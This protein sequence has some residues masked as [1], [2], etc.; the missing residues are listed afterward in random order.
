MRSG[1]GFLARIL[2]C[3]SLAL[4][5]STA[6]PGQVQ[7]VNMVPTSNSG[8][9]QR[10]S[11]PNIAVDPAN[12][13]SITASVF[14]PDPNG[15]LLGVLYFSIDGG[16]NWNLTPGFA[17]AGAAGGCIAHFCDVSLRYGST[18]GLL[19]LADL[20]I[21]GIGNTNLAVAQITNITATPP[22]YTLL[23]TRTGTAGSY[24]DQPWVEATTVLE[25]AGTGNDHTYVGNNNT[26][27]AT[28]TASVDLSLNPVPPAPSGFSADVIDASATCGQD[29]PSVRTAI[30][31]SGTV[32]IGFY[33]WT[34]SC[35]G[36]PGTAD[37]VVVRDDNW[38][39]GPNAF[40]A[41]HDL[42]NASIGQRV[43]TGIQ[44]PW[45]Q[46]LGTQRV[47]SQ[48]A[49]AVDPNDS[50]TVYIAWGDGGTGATYTLHVRHSTDSGQHWDAADLR[51]INTATNPGL[52]INSHGKVA[53][54]YQQQSGGNWHTIVERTTNAFT[55]HQDL[56]LAN[57][58]DQKGTY[59]GVNPIG[60]YDNVI[61]SSKDFYGIFSGFNTANNAN[62]PNA[63]TYQRQANFSTHQLFADAGHTMPVV[64]SIDP[65]F[66]HITE[67]AAD[68]D[69]YVRDWTNSTAPADHDNGQEPSTNTFFWTSSDVWNRSTNSAGT[70]NANDQ[71]STD[72]MQAGLAASG[73]NF[74]FV[75]VHRNG[76]GSAASV[77][78][79]FLVSPFGTGSAFQDADVAPDPTLNFAAGDQVQVLSSGYHWH[80]DPIAST[81]ACV[82]VQISSANDPFIPPGLAGSVPGWPSGIAIVEDNN[83]AQRNLDVSH[84]LSDMGAIDYALVH[85]AALFSRD[86][87][88]RYQA[89]PERAFKGEIQV[90]GGETKPFRSGDS[91]VLKNMQPG[92][93]RWIALRLTQPGAA[94]PVNFFEMDKGRTVNGF[95]I[96]AE[97]AALS[98]V[99]MENMRE[100][101]HA[102]LRLAY[103]FHLEAG[104]T[105]SGAAAQLL[106]E[107]NIS[108]EQ[109]L[110]FLDQHSKA[111]GTIV[112]ELLKNQKEKDVFDVLRTMAAL[113]QAVQQ[114]NV[115]AA[116]S[117]HSVLLH[118]LDAFTTMLQ[119]ADGD[120]ADMLQMVRWQEALYRSKRLERISCSVQLVK[121]SHEFIRG[122]GKQ[123]SHADSYASLMR[124]LDG[125]FHETSER[126]EKDRE[127]LEKAASE[128]EHNIG[129][130][131]ARLEKAHREF[132]I[133]LASITQ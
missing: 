121:E 127:D 58:P 124:G 61:A 60:D 101:A 17:P 120:P 105:E 123:R 56:T 81:H 129:E 33:R 72:P 26:Q 78:A 112:D 133:K 7:V 43:I 13:L 92:E 36:A 38:G 22:T 80:Q 68:Q 91:I 27:L 126:L 44:I 49:I 40:Q 85:N 2:C 16:Q 116:A 20:A 103:S 25:G 90:V 86:F 113:E 94:V 106:K 95:T 8:E 83:K 107:K 50:Q 31:M 115:K 18:S 12:P 71:F 23:E 96:V 98:T 53:F 128:V 4:G 10:D 62:F 74:A 32:Y 24:P 79:H 100:H 84:N 51:T 66:F 75:R 21:D 70:P 119:K 57:L 5:V 45:N 15:T 122:Y 87:V 89:A 14:T 1:S 109:Y 114:K 64:D 130:T 46:L 99:T 54:L 55:A 3:L 125:C 104:K 30:H 19:Y 59:G 132:L 29:G 118:Q 77:T 47:G 65:F 131:A 52:A 117:T 76:T 110:G 6:A 111:M 97:P 42:G 11:E 63:A 93:N 28:N 108:S 102:F 41:L 69:F 82:A 67:M 39:T 34:A 73:D 35:G 37:V 48:L 9:T 88:L